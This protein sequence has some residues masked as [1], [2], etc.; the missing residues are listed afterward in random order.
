MSL[1][2]TQNELALTSQKLEAANVS[3]FIIAY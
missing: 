3:I 1:F 2:E